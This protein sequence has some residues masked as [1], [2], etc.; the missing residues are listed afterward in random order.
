MSNRIHEG[1]IRDDIATSSDDSK[2]QLRDF[3]NALFDILRN[4]LL[5]DGHIRLHQFGSFKLKWTKERSGKNPQTGEAI[6]I[7]AHPRI[8]FTAAKALKDKVSRGETDPIVPPLVQHE[9]VTK[10]IN[11]NLPIEDKP[12]NDRDK[13]IILNPEPYLRKNL[14]PTL[15]T[16]TKRR[17]PT[18]LAAAVMLS[19]SV[20]YFI[21]QDTNTDESYYA[22]QSDTIETSSTTAA[23]F[24]SEPA[25][26]HDNQS[27]SIKI[28]TVEESSP[29]KKP[30]QKA[31]DITDTL[32]KTEATN[33]SLPIASSLIKEEATKKPLI[34]TDSLL[35]T[36]ATHIE[37][38]TFFKQRAHKLVNGDSLWRL[39]KK[40]YVNPF[41]WPHIYQANKFKIRNPNKLLI[42]R[43]I[44]LPT[45]S[46][47]PA[48]LSAEDRRNIAEGYFLVYLYHKKTN[49]PFP[50]YALL[51]AEKFDP[52]VIKDHAYDIDE[53]DWNNLQI[54]SN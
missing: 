13:K 42:G 17:F 7:P 14:P 23:P 18:S 52:E 5:A 26:K 35:A 1:A 49:K 15:I 19:V 37:T 25:T 50:Y 46:G 33:A 54:A 48:N 45:L 21:A 41:Y 27:A 32:A 53:E 4:N 16:E 22:A 40:N 10:T 24:K 12:V 11:D 20:I 43:I 9:P 36:K 30:A 31:Q 8:T 34:A 29:E 38:A 51:G 28:K 6:I 39:S 47:N 2:K 3:S 44:T